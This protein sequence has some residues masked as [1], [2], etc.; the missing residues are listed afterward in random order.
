MSESDSPYHVAEYKP[1][2]N[3]RTSDSNRSVR[4]VDV[5]KTITKEPPTTTQA[6]TTTKAPTTT[7]APTTTKAPTTTQAPTTTKALTTTLQSY[8]LTLWSRGSLIPL[9]SFVRHRPCCLSLVCLSF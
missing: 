2:G 7:Q 8:P 9:T 3:D 6:P 4:L 5:W 1:G